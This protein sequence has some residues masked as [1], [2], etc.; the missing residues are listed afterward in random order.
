MAAA[1]SLHEIIAG[2][3]GGAGTSGDLAAVLHAGGHPDLPEELLAEAVVSYAG[4]APAEV[5]EHLAPFVMAHGPIA[6]G[7]AGAGDIG[8]LPGLLATAPAGGFDDDPD[9]AAE[10]DPPVEAGDGEGDALDDLAAEPG[11]APLDMAFGHGHAAAPFDDDAS[12]VEAEPAGYTEPHQPP[13]HEELPSPADE[14]WAAPSLPD[15]APEIDDI[16]E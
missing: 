5:A 2:L 3:T 13:M 12:I 10:L 8:Q 1:R 7:D 6:E 11:W 4:T 15:E 9:L 16:D 14:L